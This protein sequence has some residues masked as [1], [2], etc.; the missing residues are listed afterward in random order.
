MTAKG[1]STLKP[2]GVEQFIGS[3]A[4]E[5]TGENAFNVRYIIW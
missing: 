2:C 4:P 5:T 3:S 1:M